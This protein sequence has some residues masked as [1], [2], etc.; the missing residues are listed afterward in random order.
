MVEHDHIE[1]AAKELHGSIHNAVK[2][3]DGQYR[4]L[5]HAILAYRD[6][7]QDPQGY[8]Q[9]LTAR[10]NRKPTIPET[11]RPF[12]WLLHAL[13]AGETV[14][15]ESWP[16]F[17]KLASAM[18]EIHREFEDTSTVT[19]EGV[20]TFIKERHGVTGLYK[21]SLEKAR[22][23]DDTDDD[24]DPQDTDDETDDD[25]HD[26]DHP[27]DCEMDND[28]TDTDTDD[29]KDDADPQ[30]APIEGVKIGACV[31]HGKDAWLEMPGY[32]GTAL[33]LMIVDQGR[34][35]VITPQESE[36]VEHAIREEAEAA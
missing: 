21:D 23:D 1:Q 17:S 12:L 32:T 24:A 13:T 25:T 34:V 35:V 33:V 8:E 14:D 16:H 20:I 15:P 27:Q 5:A 29:D 26:A 3:R 10:L 9:R 28:D 2:A 4:F 30:D 11:K 36:V 31:L 19:I 6:G 7:Q 22:D 18:E